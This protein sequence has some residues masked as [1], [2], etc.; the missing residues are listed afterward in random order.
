MKLGKSG[1]LEVIET[2]DNRLTAIDVRHLEHLR[3]LHVD[4]NQLKELDMSHNQKLEGGGF[5][6]RNNVAE[7]I[8]LP[9]QPGLIIDREDYEEQN[10]ILGHDRVVWYLDPEFT[11]QAPEY[12]EA[13]GQTLY[14]QRVPNRYTIYFSA[15]GGS[16]SM[17]GQS[18]VW[19]QEIQLPE[20]GF[21]RYGYTFSHWSEQ[22]KPDERDPVYAEGEF[23]QNLAGENTDGDRI[24]L[25][26]CW[27]PNSY[28]IWLDP[29]GGVGERQSLSAT[30]GKPVTLTVE[31]PFYKDGKELAG[32]ALQANG[33]IRYPDQGEV[34]N[35]TGEPEGE[36]TLYAVWRTPISELQKPYLWELEE[37]FQSYA[38]SQ[39][40]TNYTSQDWEMLSNAYA[41]A[42]EQIQQAQF[43]EQMKTAVARGREAM[44]QVPTRE[45][46]VEE[47]TGDWRQAHQK[48]LSYLQTAKLTESNAAEGEQLAQAALD[49]LNE[50]QLGQD[51]PLERPEDRAQ[52]IGQARA[53][54]EETAQQL[55]DLQGA[56]R[57]LE[58]LGGLTLCGMS[59]VRGDDLDAYQQAMLHYQEL[60]Q[61]KRAYLSARV[62]K[63]LEERSEL[64]GQKR[65]EVLTLESAYGGLDLTQY[66]TK[67]QAALAQA[68][69]DGVEAIEQASSV[70]QV[71]QA[72]TD[73]WAAICQ[74][75]VAGEEPEEPSEPPAGGG[76]GS[77]GGGSAGGGGGGGSAPEQP[78]EKPEEDT[79]QTVTDSK[80]GAS[81]VVTTT[82]DGAVSA[83]VTLPQGVAQAVLAIPCAGDSNTVAVFVE[84]DGS[85]RV[86]PRSVYRDGVLMVRMDRSGRIE[87]VQR[88]PSFTDVSEEDWFA[89]PVQFAAGRELF[90]GIG[91]GAF[92]PQET[93]SRAILVTV[94]YQLEERPE[95]GDETAFQDV[96]AGA[97]YQKAAQ[98]AAGQG[99]TGGTGEG[100]FSPQASISRESLALMLYRCAGSPEL[101]P[102][103]REQLSRFRD[104][105]L[106][107]SWSRD[108]VAWACAN[109]IMAGDP[110]GR[111]TPQGASTRAQVAAMVAQFVS[112]TTQ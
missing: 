5:V 97:W 102:G 8:Y 95:V 65:G 96:P 17:A 68:L 111:L 98:W 86:L 60:D 34:Q 99:I 9:N 27:Q 46:R 37:L 23:V 44:E 93:M 36:V 94:L 1:D 91:A 41:Q 106:V 12:L 42:V 100:R 109:G 43:E 80:T 74:I 10:P 79:E 73:A 48:A 58:G 82:A 52:V 7:R 59:Q 49:G 30:Y 103:E 31:K 84:Q 105:D 19:D 64:A 13:E 85:T 55:L 78:E 29:N 25:Y 75:P 69:K 63:S 70:S 101:S 3:F 26:A 104:G 35:L 87:L 57:W 66:S 110:Q 77:G 45:D 11:V 50:E 108:A 71:Q 33:T 14:S 76:G 2:F 40:G 89:Q 83:Q 22:A 6:V 15:N 47:V 112:L 88:T 39:G 72:R 28:T 20:N 107:S 18:A 92:G 16:G 24:T 90:S 62:Y 54:L 4:H 81:A 38:A 67:G 53:N 32:W 56:A 61:G 51:C 21:R